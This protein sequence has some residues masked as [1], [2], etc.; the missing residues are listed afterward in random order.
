MSHD[1]RQQITIFRHLNSVF[2]LRIMECSCH[3]L[4]PR[5]KTAIFTGGRQNGDLAMY[6]VLSLLTLL[7]SFCWLELEVVWHPLA[8]QNARVHPNEIARL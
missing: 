1:V 7:A 3:R 2:H 8:L 6:V 5:G 4:V